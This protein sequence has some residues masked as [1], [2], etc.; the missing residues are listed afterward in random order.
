MYTDLTTTFVEV[1][2][3]LLKNPRLNCGKT[4]YKEEEE[5][6]GENIA[7]IKGSGCPKK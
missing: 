1:K 3:L 4:K 7:T 5:N 6:N 2:K